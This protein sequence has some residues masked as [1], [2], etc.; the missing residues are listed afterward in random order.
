[1]LLESFKAGSDAGYVIIPGMSERIGYVQYNYAGMTAREV[2]A[3]KHA[4]TIPEVRRSHPETPD[5]YIKVLQGL[6]IRCAVAG[7]EACTALRQEYNAIPLH[8]REK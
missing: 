6:G 7:T 1:M 5:A 4:I 2:S 3:W 8:R